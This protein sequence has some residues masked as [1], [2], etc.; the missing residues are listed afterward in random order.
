ME[1]KFKGNLEYKL[2]ITYDTDTDEITDISESVIR[3]DDEVVTHNYG[4]ITLDD[5]WDDET[6]E[7]M[8]KVYEVG[9]A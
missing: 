6:Y 7:L 2:I 1:K 8:Q 5:Y 4:E 3:L 9:E